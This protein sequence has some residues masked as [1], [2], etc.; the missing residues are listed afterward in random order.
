[1]RVGIVPTHLSKKGH[2]RIPSLTMVRKLS[3]EKLCSKTNKYIYI[4]PFYRYK[5]MF[6]Y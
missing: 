3:L 2:T 5:K 6:S 1:M 4:I